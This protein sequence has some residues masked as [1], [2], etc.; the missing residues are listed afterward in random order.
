M[1]VAD[2][3]EP[4]GTIRNYLSELK[5]TALIEGKREL[6]ASDAS[7][8]QSARHQTR[9]AKEIGTI[10]RA[11]RSVFFFQIKRIAY[12]R[13][14]QQVNGLLA[15]SIQPLDCVAAFSLPAEFIDRTE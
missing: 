12:T 7:F 4:S 8:N 9:L 11:K 5:T 14:R 10:L 1:A 13:R 2:G 3:G 6:P 15:M